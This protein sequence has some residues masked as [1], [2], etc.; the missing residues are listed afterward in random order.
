MTKEEIKEL[1]ARVYDISWSGFPLDTFFNDIRD[2][3]SPNFN[4]EL[5]YEDLKKIVDEVYRLR[6]LKKA[7]KFLEDETKLYIEKDEFGYTLWVG[8]TGYKINKEE[9]EL[10]E[11]IL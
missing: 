2:N 4:K 11:E 1:Q 7:I 8:G 3:P 5:A 6:K 10:F 9:Y